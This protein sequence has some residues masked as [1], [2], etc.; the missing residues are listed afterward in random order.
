MPQRWAK[1]VLLIPKIAEASLVLTVYLTQ[2]Y[3][4]LL[5]ALGKH[6]AD[7]LVSSLKTNIFHQNDCPV[8]NAWASSIFDQAMREQE[9]PAVAGKTPPTG[10][11]LV[12]VLPPHKFKS[13]KTGGKANSFIVE[14]YV[15]APG[16]R[17][18][19]TKARFHQLQPGKSWSARILPK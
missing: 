2:N 16:L 11:A 13:L 5:D 7:S 9:Y 4:N 15:M 3:P 6:P 17:V 14:G 1:S 19:S 12:P 10:M 8:T 18:A